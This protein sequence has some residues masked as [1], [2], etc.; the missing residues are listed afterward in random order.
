[1]RGLAVSEIHLTVVVMD[2][3][4]MSVAATTAAA[5]KNAAK[6]GA[7]VTV[8]R[9]VTRR[10]VAAIPIAGNPRSSCATMI[11]GP[12][13]AVPRVMRSAIRIVVER[14]TARPMMNRRLRNAAP[15][16]AMK[17]VKGT[18]SVVTK[19]IRSVFRSIRMIQTVMKSAV[20]S[21]TTAF[22]TTNVALASVSN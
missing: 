14:A 1:M 11:V 3:V 17:S 2:V 10:S 8:R 20:I 22:V 7:A 19:K 5:R 16:L 6:E 9:S 21:V 13:S 4:S 12:V 18:L 15:V